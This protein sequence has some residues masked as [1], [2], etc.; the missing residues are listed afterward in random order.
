MLSKSYDLHKNQRHLV[1]VDCRVQENKIPSCGK[2]TSNG[3]LNIIHL[4]TIWRQLCLKLLVLQ[5]KLIILLILMI[6]D[7]I[8]SE[9]YKNRLESTYD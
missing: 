8:E 5:I 3:L 7:S 2:Y 4:N 6:T 9:I 1:F